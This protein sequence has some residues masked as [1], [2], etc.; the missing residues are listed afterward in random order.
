MDVRNF[1]W[2]LMNILMEVCT[3]NVVHRVGYLRAEAVS[4]SHLADQFAFKVAQ[5]FRLTWSGIS[6]EARVSCAKKVSDWRE[7]KK[8]REW[9]NSHTRVYTTRWCA[10]VATASVRS[11]TTTTITGGRVFIVWHART[12]TLL[13][14]YTKHLRNY[15]HDRCDGNERALPRKKERE[16]SERLSL[17]NANSIL[18]TRADVFIGVRPAACCWRGEHP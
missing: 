8:E 1:V 14:V 7:R 10:A 6:R 16:R 3:E 4:L 12:E 11:A 9:E 18:I 2:R 17:H 15:G 13:R 5:L